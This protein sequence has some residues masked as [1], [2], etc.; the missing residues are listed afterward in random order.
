MRK[1][2]LLETDLKYDEDDMKIKYFHL[3][4]NKDMLSFEDEI[5]FK[6]NGVW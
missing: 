3:F 6:E 5:F 4:K 2:G 1:L